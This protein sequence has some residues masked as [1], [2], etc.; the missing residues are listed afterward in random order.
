MSNSRSVISA[1][2][3]LH[4]KAAFALSNLHS[5]RMRRAES[6]DPLLTGLSVTRDELSSA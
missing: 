4:L 2:I 6:R 5:V 1:N 3:L